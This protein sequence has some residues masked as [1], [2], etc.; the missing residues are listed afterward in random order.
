MRRAA[1]WNPDPWWSRARALERTDLRLG[2]VVGAQ[3]GR[4]CLRVQSHE[5]HVEEITYDHLIVALGSV[6]LTDGGRLV[7]DRHLQ[8]A[9]HPNVWAVGDAG[10]V[11]R[12]A[13]KGRPPTPPTAQ[14]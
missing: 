7:V 5:G 1:R 3:P 12:P 4:N 9:G 11:P 13:R 8:V 14:H 10:A 6:S 2:S